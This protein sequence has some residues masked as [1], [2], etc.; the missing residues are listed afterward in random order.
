MGTATT[1]A[2]AIRTA[3]SGMAFLR[4]ALVIPAEGFLV[5]YS[6]LFCMESRVA[7]RDLRLESLMYSMD[8][9]QS[10]Q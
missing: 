2:M 6:R 7:C 9:Y 4:S 5:R 10:F 8:W 1:K 3:S